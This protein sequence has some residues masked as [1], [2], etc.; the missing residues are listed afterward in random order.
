MKKQRQK[1]YL[2]E[3]MYFNPG[4]IYG[5]FAN[6]EDAKDFA[7]SISGGTFKCAVVPRTLF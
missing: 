4:R 6:E 2:V 1:V 5:V 7:D 3:D